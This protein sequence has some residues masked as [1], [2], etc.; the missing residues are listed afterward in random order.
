M[1]KI[2]YKSK[3]DFENIIDRDNLDSN[4]I[5]DMPNLATLPYNSS[6]L[7]LSHNLQTTLENLGYDVEKDEV[8]STEGSYSDQVQNLNI[9]F[10]G[11]KRDDIQ[12]KV[13]LSRSLKPLLMSL[14]GLILLS[15]GIM[16]GSY[17]LDLL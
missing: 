5:K 12:G 9:H 17:G 1:E 11:R 16:L 14:I 2:S 4:K 7:K 6:L 8:S 10:F 15:F 3:E 13:G